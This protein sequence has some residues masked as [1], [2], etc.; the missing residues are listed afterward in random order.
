VRDGLITEGVTVQDVHVWIDSR[1]RP[2]RLFTSLEVLTPGEPQV[3]ADTDI[4]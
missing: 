1:Q 4:N 2:V 3:A